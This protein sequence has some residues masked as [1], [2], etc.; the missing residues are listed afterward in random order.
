LTAVWSA[1]VAA[2]PE[3]P[4]DRAGIL[5]LAREVAAVL[6]HSGDALLTAQQVAARFN[7]D[8]SWVYAHADELG[9]V[10]LGDGPRPRLRFHAA[11]VAQRLLAHPGRVLA[12]TPSTP[13]RA[14]APLLPIRPSR[15]R[16]SV[17]QP[18]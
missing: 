9:V 7:V 6:G 5:A 13:V 3:P 16:R 10:R 14:A 17:D 15:R 1:D 11:V 4:L 8:R 2:A 18:R 12:A